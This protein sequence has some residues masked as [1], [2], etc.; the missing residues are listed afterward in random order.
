MSTTFAGMP[1]YPYLYA[2]DL[3]AVLKQ[4]HASGTYKSMVNF[5]FPIVHSVVCH[6]GVGIV[7]DH[8]IPAGVLS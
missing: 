8:V 7:V 4:K 2:N 5:Y 6:R 3:I 1:T